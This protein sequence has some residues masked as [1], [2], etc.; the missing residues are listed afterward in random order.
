MD[1]QRERCPACDTLFQGSFCHECGEKRISPE[2]KKLRHFLE[3]LVASVFVADGKFFRTIKLLISKPGALT[4]SFILGVRKKYLSPF[5]MFFFAN[6]IYFIFPVISTFNTSLYIQMNGLPYSAIVRP[7]VEQKVQ[8][9]GLKMEEFTEV[10]E[11]NSESIAKLL[12]II[13]VIM[14][15]VVLRVLFRKRRDLYFLDFLA[16]AAYFYGFYILIFLVAVPGLFVLL[17]NQLDFRF[18]WFFNETSLSIFFL[19]AIWIYGFFQM[20]RAF[21][22]SKWE[23][24]WKSLV[25]GLW[26]IPGFI[27]Y[28]FI[29]FWVSFWMSS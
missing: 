27:I 4:H 23:S 14:Q 21:T 17:Q 13:L 24:L 2:D 5:Q 20:K 1:T 12:L 7:L 18:G 10:F 28:R 16:E 25:L 9:E 29:L 8:D 11:R 6:L 19:V 3:E 15:G 22:I 26:V